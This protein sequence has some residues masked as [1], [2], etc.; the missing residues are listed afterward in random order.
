MT[1][2]AK[3]GIKGFFDEATNTVSYLVWDPATMD[4]VAIDPVLDFDHRSGKATVESADAM[5]A[6]AARLGEEAIARDRAYAPVYDLV[7]AAYTRLGR[8]TDAR[9][10][11]ETSLTFDGRDSTAYT[12]LG[13]L[14]LAE[15]NRDRARG[16]FAEALWLTPDSATARAGLARARE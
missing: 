4:G 16:Y 7:G 11:F 5:L 8:A 13:L 9:R 10:A 1:V 3:A 2:D 14:A 6:E 12:N 15:G